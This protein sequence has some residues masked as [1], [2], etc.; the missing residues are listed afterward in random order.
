MSENVFKMI[1]NQ[2]DLHFMPIHS[3]RT[4]LGISVLESCYILKALANVL[5]GFPQ[6]YAQT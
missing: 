3:S 6:S 2:Q 1:R 4:A 5:A